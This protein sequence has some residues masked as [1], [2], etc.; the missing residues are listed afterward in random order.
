MEGLLV[1]IVAIG[2]SS[3]AMWYG[4]YKTRRDNK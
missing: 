1:L 2:L 4:L 3:G